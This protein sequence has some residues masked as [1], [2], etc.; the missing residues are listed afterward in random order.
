M[1]LTPHDLEQLERES[2]ID[3]PTT[4]V[5][6]LRR[7]DTHE[8]AELVGRSDREDYAGIVFPVY[9]PGDSEPREYFLRRDHPHI[10]NGKPKNK[11]M[12][13]PGRPNM[14]LFGPGESVDALADTTRPMVLVE[15][16]KKLCAAYRL[17]RHNTDIPQFLTCAI[18]GVWNW[19]GK[20]G[21]TTDATG[22][23]VDEKGPVPDFNRIT[24]PGR[25]VVVVFDSDCATNRKV[26]AARHRLL[27]EL[28][29]RGAHAVALDLPSLEG[30]A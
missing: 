4:E 11:Y 17:A 20:I 10:E 15:G 27:A 22:A 9:W 3:R 26:A 19:R 24:W 14:L 13:P 25:K 1:T 8:G 29:K 2:G 23:R 7:V 28:K 30:G 5:F 6:Q 18:S 12:G 16:L 21:K